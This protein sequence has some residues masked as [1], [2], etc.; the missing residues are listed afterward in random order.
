MAFDLEAASQHPAAKTGVG[1][2]FE[3]THKMVSLLT[4]RVSDGTQYGTKTHAQGPGQRCLFNSVSVR[5]C[6]RHERL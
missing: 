6:E 1:V 3:V 2:A 4:S 5:A